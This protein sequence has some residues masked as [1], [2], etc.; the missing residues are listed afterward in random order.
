[1]LAG[2]NDSEKVSRND[3]HSGFSGDEENVFLGV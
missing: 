1:M 3:G 2:V